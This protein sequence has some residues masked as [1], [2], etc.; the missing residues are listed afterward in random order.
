M[1]GKQDAM[2]RR[3]AA[4]IYSAWQS[5]G[6]TPFG[7]TKGSP[8]PRHPQVIGKEF[9][10]H[11]EGLAHNSRVSETMRNWATACAYSV[12][13]DVACSVTAPEDEDGKKWCEELKG[14]RDAYHRVMDSVNKDWRKWSGKLLELMAEGLEAVQGDFLSEVFERGVEATNRHNGQFLTPASVSRFMGHIIFGENATP[15]LIVEME[16]PCCGTGVLVAEGVRGFLESG[17][18][19]EDIVVR[20]GDIDEGACCTCYL[21]LTALSIP[22]IVQAADALAMQAR[23]PA[24]VTPAYI[25]F[26]VHRRLRMQNVL[27]TME[28][29]F[30][31]PRLKRAQEAP[32]EAEEPQEATTPSPALQDAPAADVAPV[33]E[34]PTGPVQMEMFPGAG[35]P[36]KAEQLE[37]FT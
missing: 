13:L 18:R 36:Q 11:M 16:E 4:P 12:A 14:R 15:G 10:K 24:M 26:D 37:L 3:S 25:L 5:D 19:K 35:L 31:D 34:E 9:V 33:E 32:A 22:A 28:T 8:T 1:G 20:A 6:K 30:R 2:S 17:G 29:V 27:K 21:Q 7:I 23:G